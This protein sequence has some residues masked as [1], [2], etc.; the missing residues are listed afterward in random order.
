MFIKHIFVPHL[1]DTFLDLGPDIV[2]LCTRE[3]VLNV[4][5]NS[6]TI[7]YEQIMGETFMMDITNPFKP[8]INIE[9]VRGRFILKAYADEDLTDTVAILSGPIDIMNDITM[10][11]KIGVPPVVVSIAGIYTQKVN[12]FFRWRDI[13]GRVRWTPPNFMPNNATSI[14]AYNLNNFV[15]LAEDIVLNVVTIKSDTAFGLEVY[16]DIGGGN[17][18]SRSGGNWFF[19]NHAQTDE[20]WPLSIGFKDRSNFSRTIYFKSLHTYVDTPNSITRVIK[21]NFTRTIYTKTSLVYEDTPNSIRK[22]TFG[23]FTRTIY[24]DRIIA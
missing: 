1:E 23:N 21:S 18:F 16:Y 4:N 3:F 17:K 9:Q 22:T 10:T 13:G 20:R 7:R 12:E 5:T 14:K 2:A 6:S 11:T 24:N 15:T 8:I 19:A